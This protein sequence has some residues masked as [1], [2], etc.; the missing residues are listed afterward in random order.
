MGMIALHIAYHHQHPL[1]YYGQS[2]MGTLQGYAGA[3]LFHVFGPSLFALRLG[4]VLMFALYLIVMYQLTSLLYSR[5]LALVTLFLLGFAPRDLLYHQVIA[6]GGHAELPLFGAL[7]LLF[8]CWL[9]LTY[10]P[11]QFS[12]WRLL[13]Y[14]LWGGVAGLAI[15]DDYLIMPFVIMSALLLIVVCL[16]ELR[17]RVLISTF[18]AL[19]LGALPLILFTILHHGSSSSSP[20]T[21]LNLTMSWRGQTNT[22]LDSIIGTIMV[23]LPIVT[24][25]YSL[26]PVQPNNI[27]P[28]LGLSSPSAWGCATTHIAAASGFLLLLLIALGQAAYSYWQ[29]A[30][31]SSPNRRQD[32]ESE[33]TRANE[34]GGRGSARLHLARLALLGTAVLTLLAYVVTPQP[35]MSPAS[36]SRYLV[37]LPIVFPA[38]LWPVWSGISMIRWSKSAPL[39][40]N[41]WLVAQYA[42][43][44]F[45]LIL[46]F[47][48][49]V[50][51]LQA[52]SQAQ[53]VSEQQYAMIHDLEHLG[54]KHFYTEYWTCDRVAFQSMEQ[55]TCSVLNDGLRPGMNRYLPYRAA[56]RSDPHA[57]Y[58]FPDSDPAAVAALIQ[59][60][61]HTEKPG[62]LLH[63]DGYTIYLPVS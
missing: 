35:A 34:D 22:P 18:L 10:V 42:L 11:Q 4:L 44:A 14:V 51:T 40:R 17:I 50:E 56:V 19:V 25:G 45:M 12:P 61:Q 23:A 3:L 60:V 33:S 58:A 21:I 52:V 48:S 59:K 16:G 13:L 27:K 2:Y 57:A 49:V 54:V 63:M 36:T 1:I 62:R 31:T 29:L 46:P 37:A 5:G 39:Q 9:A 15:W 20:G 47:A 26:C 55:L 41:A 8:A 24:G 43:L 28:L 38:L 53:S 7:L 32:K 6:I 30:R